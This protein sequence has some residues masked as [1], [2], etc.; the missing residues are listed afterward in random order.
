MFHFLNSLLE[1]GLTLRINR[2]CEKQAPANRI[3]DDPRIG[4]T[5]SFRNLVRHARIN[6]T[7]KK[8]FVYPYWLLASLLM[9]IEAETVWL[10]SATIMNVQLWPRGIVFVTPFGISITPACSVNICGHAESTEFV[11]SIGQTILVQCIHSQFKAGLMYVLF[12]QLTIETIDE[13]LVS[14]NKACNN[15]PSVTVNKARQ[16]LK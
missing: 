7:S 3:N 13:T 15:N 1:G 14:K 10:A 2:S 16:L 12:K 4:F 8:S 5:C 6:L 11:F 9:L